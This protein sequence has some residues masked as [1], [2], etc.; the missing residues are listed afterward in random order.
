MAARQTYS[1]N[2]QQ[3]SGMYVDGNT[4]T[5]PAAEPRRH[6]KSPERPKKKDKQQT[7]P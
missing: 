4:V 6:E 3:Y 2:R 7:G 5:K 1:R